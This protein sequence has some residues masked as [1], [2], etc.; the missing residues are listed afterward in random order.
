VPREC[1]LDA[2]QNGVRHEGRGRVHEWERGARSR[3]PRRVLDMVRARAAAGP[4]AG[5]SGWHRL[6]GVDG[7]QWAL[8]ARQQR[9]AYR[10][11]LGLHGRAHGR[12]RREEEGRWG[13]GVGVAGKWGRGGPPGR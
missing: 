2:V 10:R 3:H 5:R 7:G 13:A 8:M 12:R 1:T 4:M 9:L 6:G 11:S